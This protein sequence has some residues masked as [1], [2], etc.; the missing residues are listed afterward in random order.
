MLYARESYVL[1]RGFLLL[2]VLDVELYVG[3]WIDYLCSALLIVTQPVNSQICGAH[4]SGYI[5]MD[6]ITGASLF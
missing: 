4:Q 6:M 3:L 1:Q 2:S 5:K